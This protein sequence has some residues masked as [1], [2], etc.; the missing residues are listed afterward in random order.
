MYI[1]DETV[2]IALRDLIA[3]RDEDDKDCWDIKDECVL[4][5]DL[6][7]NV[8]RQWGSHDIRPGCF[9]G[10]CSI[11]CVQDH[12]TQSSAVLVSDIGRVQAFRSDG[13]L[14]RTWT[15]AVCGEE[16]GAILQLSSIHPQELVFMLECLG[17]RVDVF[18]LHGSRCFTFPVIAEPRD[19][20]CGP[21]EVYVLNARQ[22]A[23]Y[24]ALDGTELRTVPIPQ[25]STAYVSMVY[26]PNATLAI[27]SWCTTGLQDSLIIVISAGDG[28]LLGHA[29]CNAQTSMLSWQEKHSD[30]VSLPYGDWK[31]DTAPLFNVRL[32]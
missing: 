6:R 1:H 9:S 3:L 5:T 17:D 16:L 27:A 24:S 23:V 25:Q 19:M 30:L 31:T 22:V 15:S 29:S 18:N 2:F 12:M 21:E 4:V 14:F 20:S 11:V 13:Q 8:V 26:G 28:S 10:I 32:L 7:G